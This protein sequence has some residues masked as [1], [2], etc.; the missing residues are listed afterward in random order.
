MKLIHL[1]QA[2]YVPEAVA[3]FFSQQ[4]GRLTEY[5]PTLFSSSQYI[6]LTQ[7]R[8]YY[9]LILTDL[10]RTII[11]ITQA[12]SSHNFHKPSVNGIN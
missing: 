1:H 3:Q 2:N 12:C 10:S 8:C 6:S 7:H 5:G 11:H 4:T 9:A